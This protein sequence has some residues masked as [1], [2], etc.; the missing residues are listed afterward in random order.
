MKLKNF[1]TMLF[2]SRI[3]FSAFATEE[4]LKRTI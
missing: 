1:A 4:R 2:F 3:G